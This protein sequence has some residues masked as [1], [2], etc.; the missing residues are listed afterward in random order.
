[1]AIDTRVVKKVVSQKMDQ[2][3]T[4]T[5]LAK[6][7]GSSPDALKKQFKRKEGISIAKYIRTIR[8]ERVKFLLLESN[9][10]CKEIC[11]TLG[12][13]RED[14]GSHVFKRETGISMQEFRRVGKIE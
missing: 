10:R 9:L 5:D 13:S 4:I 1:M 6:I 12:F 8:I 3:R 7:V 2:I 14:L 11:L